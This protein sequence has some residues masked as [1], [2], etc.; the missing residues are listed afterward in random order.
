MITEINTF[1]DWM[2]SNRHSSYTFSE[3]LWD[4]YDLKV[5]PETIQRWMAEKPISE[6]YRKTVMKETKLRFSK[7]SGLLV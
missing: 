2:N 5:S 3:L 6:R 4:K 7:E 1:K